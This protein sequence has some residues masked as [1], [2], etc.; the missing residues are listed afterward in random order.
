MA[1]SHSINVIIFLHLMPLNKS[2]ASDGLPTEV[3]EIFWDEVGIFVVNVCD[4]ALYLVHISDVQDR[5]FITFIS[6]A[7]KGQRFVKNSVIFF[8]ILIIRYLQNF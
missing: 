1:L 4:R 6:K 3:D 2:P 8:Y 5:A 7:S